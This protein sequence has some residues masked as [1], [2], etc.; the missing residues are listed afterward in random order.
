MPLTQYHLDGLRQMF[1]C[2]VPDFLAAWRRDPPSDSDSEEVNKVP[3]PITEMVIAEFHPEGITIEARQYWDGE[4]EGSTIPADELAQ[5]V[6]HFER[7]FRAMVVGEGRPCKIGDARMFDY[8]FKVSGSMA[9]FLQ[10]PTENWGYLEEKGN[11]R[12]LKEALDE[13]S[14]KTATFLLSEEPPREDFC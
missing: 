14:R 9:I 5:D 12:A 2:A 1:I 3:L 13:F 4:S 7:H 8:C 11:A 6:T 10:H